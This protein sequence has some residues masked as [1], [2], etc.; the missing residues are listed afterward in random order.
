MAGFEHKIY[1]L[2]ALKE[3]LYME[4]YKHKQCNIHTYSI[5]FLTTGHIKSHVLAACS[6]SN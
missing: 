4:F 2:L 5:F 3:T 1:A 6:F